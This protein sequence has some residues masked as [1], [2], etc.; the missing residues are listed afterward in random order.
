[1]TV[2]FEE[3][4]DAIEAEVKGRDPDT[5]LA[6]LK[7]DPTGE[8]RTAC[9]W[10][11]R[12]A[13]RS[14]TRWWRSATRSASQR[15]VTT[16]IVSALQRQVDAPNG[17]PI[18]DVIQ[19]DASI[20]PGNSGGPLLDANGQRDRHQLPDRHGRRRQGSVGIGFAVPINTAKQLLP[21]LEQGTDVKHAYLGVTHGAT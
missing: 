21:K 4:G 10:A 8:E 9:R 11:T 18:S 19:T 2:S 17:F 12:L 13:P 6:V 16:G 5:D 14:A 20:N 7:V 3:G 15:T 1:M